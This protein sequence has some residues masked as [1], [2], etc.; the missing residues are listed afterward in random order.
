VPKFDG[1]D[2]SKYHS[3]RQAWA[4]AEQKLDRMGKTPAEKLLDLKKVL[5][6]NA[7]KYIGSLTDSKDKNYLG[8]LKMLDRHY[9]DKQLT[10]KEAIERLMNLSRM[11]NDPSSIEETFFSLSNI[12]QI[13]RGL[14][15]TDKE[16]KTLIFTSI[17]EQKLTNPIR[18][19]WAKR[20]EDKRSKSHPL[21]HRAKV[22]DFFEVIERE[23]KLSR[24]MSHSSTKQDD[25]KKKEKQETKKEDKRSLYSSFGANKKD[26]KEESH[27]L[28]CVFCSK[29]HKSSKCQTFRDKSIHDRWEMVKAKK[30]CSLCF[31]THENFKDCTFKPCDINGCGKRHSRL[32]HNPK[33]SSSTSRPSSH[34][35]QTKTSETAP[36]QNNTPS[37]SSEKAP[38][39]CS[40]LSNTSGKNKIAILQSCIAWAVSPSGEKHRAR[41][42]IDLGSEISLI[43]RQMAAIMGLQGRPTTL[44]MNVAGGGETS[45]TKEKEVTFRLESLDGKYTT[46]LIEATTTSTISK[47]LRAIPIKISDFAHLR[48]LTFT[49]TFPRGEVDVD[50]MVGLPYYNWLIKDQPIMGQPS[51]PMALPTKLGMVLTGSCLTKNQD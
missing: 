27:T 16:F 45:P 6:G 44:Q 15:L 13:I 1:T 21:G 22:S 2:I 46:P 32:L 9:H 30:L 35:A 38:S 25:G 23:L 5:S 20:C 10:G 18:K 17:A 41:I 24:S 43:T 42:F 8:A 50:I 34:S 39:S 4:S 29:P 49:E 47:G 12:Y 19:A 33:S 3:F 36:P 40:A 51:E 48:N 37:N 26:S 31:R 28:K 14:D 11:T 7:L